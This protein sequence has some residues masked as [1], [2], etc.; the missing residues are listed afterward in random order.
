[1][2]APDPRAA[3]TTSDRTRRPR[4]RTATVAAT[5][6][7]VLLAG[8]AAA[9]GGARRPPPLDVRLT[10]GTAYLGRVPFR[11]FTNT[12]GSPRIE[13]PVFLEALYVRVA[14]RL[15]QWALDERLQVDPNYLAAIFLRESAGDTLA[16]S[17]SGA[18]GLAQLTPA[19]DADLRSAVQAPALAWA[20]EEVEGWPRDAAIRAGQGADSIRARLARGALTARTEY[21]FD[22]VLSA[23]AATLYVRLLRDRWSLDGAPGSAAGG[24][25]GGAYAT[26]AR[27]AIGQGR[28]L[29]A[30]QLFE[31]VTVSYARG[32]VWTRGVV[33]RFGREWVR[34]LP[35]AGPEG[36]EAAD[37]LGRVRAYTYL[38]KS[39]PYR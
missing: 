25:A 2:P 36:V 7:A 3:R 27:N 22:P 1:M 5:L 8:G 15:E 39:A 32:P 14:P 24:A 18:L 20:R 21:L 16:V 34:R 26:F 30:D 37:Y 23:R 33:E 12:D 29:S 38:L 13:N 19:V 28:P 17:R 9:C 6:A 11:A 10:E 35:E 31:L 4:R